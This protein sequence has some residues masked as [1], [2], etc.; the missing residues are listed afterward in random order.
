MQF[1]MLHE[2]FVDHDNGS[3]LKGRF[4]RFYTTRVWD[5][6]GC[7]PLPSSQAFMGEQLVQGRYAVA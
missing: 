3:L 1:W 4:I 6:W 2:L 5:E 7:F